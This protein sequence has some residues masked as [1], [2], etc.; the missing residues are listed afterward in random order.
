MRR[1]SRLPIFV[2]CLGTALSSPVLSAQEK[3]EPVIS[4]YL[5]DYRVQSDTIPR[6]YGTT[7]LILFAAAV[8]DDGSIDFSRIDGDLFR[9]AK[10]AKEQ[11]PALR[12]TVCVGGWRKSGSFASAVSTAEHR[13]RFVNELVQFCDAHQLDGVDIN[14]EFPKGEREHADFGLFLET[15]SRALQPRERILTVALGYTRPLPAETWAHIDYVNLMS[16]QPWTIQDYE[17]WLTSSI[18]RFLESGLPPEKLLLG[19]GFFAKEKAG[20]R[21]AYSWKTLLERESKAPP[22]SEH[23]FWP[24]GPETCDLRVR[25]VKEHGLGGVMIWDY[26]H[27]SLSPEHSLLRHLSRKLAPPPPQ[28]AEPNTPQKGISSPSSSP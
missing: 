16:Y 17:P 19:V 27:D 15:L 20:D 22:T 23:G 9:F 21:R 13:Q 5:P 2:F 10:H 8:Q 7:H 14:W 24:V 28:R 3:A 6:V 18:E 1:F 26:G 12:V 4:V 11:N 25:L